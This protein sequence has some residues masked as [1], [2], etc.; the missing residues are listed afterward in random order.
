VSVGFNKEYTLMAIFR[1]F[2]G[3]KRDEQATIH[4]E[5]FIG[6][7]LM[8]VVVEI[9]CTGLFRPF[10]PIK[11]QIAAGGGIAGT[12]IE[13]PIVAVDCTMRQYRACHRPAGRVIYRFSPDWG[14]TF[15]PPARSVG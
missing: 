6:I 3:Y 4:C 8:E 12:A 5:A 2:Q 1:R 9:C 7:C 11:K 10:A 14:G 13:R 15:R